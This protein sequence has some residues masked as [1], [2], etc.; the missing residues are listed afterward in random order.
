[1]TAPTREEITTVDKADPS[2]PT[3]RFMG[4]AVG[5]LVCHDGRPR[6]TLSKTMASP[7]WR[8]AFTPAQPAPSLES[9]YWE[10]LVPAVYHQGPKAPCAEFHA[11][12]QHG[13]DLVGAFSTERAGAS[14]SAR[15]SIPKHRLASWATQA[16][17]RPERERALLPGSRP[18]LAVYLAG[19]LASSATL[20]RPSTHIVKLDMPELPHLML[21]E[22]IVMRAAA[23]L[24]VKVVPTQLLR[25]PSALLVERTDRRR[26]AHGQVLRLQQL[27]CAQILGAPQAGAQHL[28]TV[29]DLVTRTCAYPA[30]DKLELLRRAIFNQLFGNQDFHYRSVAFSV[31]AER[32]ALAPAQ[33]LYCSVVYPQLANADGLRLGATLHF[34]WLRADHWIALAQHARMKPGFLFSEIRRLAEQ[35]PPALKRCAEELCASNAE[36]QFVEKILRIVAARSARMLD[37]VTMAAHQSLPWLGARKDQPRAAAPPTPPAPRHEDVSDPGEPIY[38]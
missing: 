31:S 36:R 25:D 21:N 37:L 1:M 19:D 20:K 9:A 26:A 24:G 12:A 13:E 17:Q 3:L 8:R 5:E 15:E 22:A 27:E 34:E 6:A 7:L 35:A 2:S 38:E 33:G 11:L 10:S 30:A 14:A 4:R 23:R 29:L 16:L 28:E 18:K 32:I